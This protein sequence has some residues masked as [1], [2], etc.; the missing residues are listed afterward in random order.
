[1]LLQAFTG[2]DLEAEVAL[3]CSFCPLVGIVL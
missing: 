2:Q 3:S 1:M